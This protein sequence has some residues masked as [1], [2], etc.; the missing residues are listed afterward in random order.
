MFW[1]CTVKD[2]GLMYDSWYSV[3]Q[4]SRA[5]IH[6]CVCGIGPK[7]ALRVAAAP[8]TDGTVPALVASALPEHPAR[9]AASTLV[10]G[11]PPGL[12]TR[13]A[14]AEAVQQVRPRAF[15]SID[16]S[17]KLWHRET[18]CQEAQLLCL[19]E[20]VNELSAINFSAPLA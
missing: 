16:G 7:C 2:V 9:H 8:S 3:K 10:A 6:I 13:G 20:K 11:V 1:G 5:C 14:V 17:W 15:P 18:D 12:G 4:R 19:H